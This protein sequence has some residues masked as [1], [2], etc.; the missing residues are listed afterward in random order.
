M[1]LPG[2]GLE[3]GGPEPSF[4]NQRYTNL[5]E[6]EAFY[7]D[8]AK[9][10]DPGCDPMVALCET[11]LRPNDYVGE[12]A[13]AVRCIFYSSAIPKAVALPSWWNAVADA[14]QSAPVSREWPAA[15]RALASACD[16]SC[17]D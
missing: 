16:S 11:D 6:L 10:F 1:V 9:R 8:A 17:A 7:D 14:R 4:E 2:C 3:G 13:A 15:I 12:F 5:D